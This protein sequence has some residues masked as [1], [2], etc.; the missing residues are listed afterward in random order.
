MIKERTLLTLST[1]CPRLNHRRRIAQDYDVGKRQALV[2]HHTRPHCA[3][4]RISEG[5]AN[6]PWTE[7]S[8]RVDQSA[9]LR[10]SGFLG[11]SSETRERLYRAYTSHVHSYSTT[12]DTASRD[13]SSEAVCNSGVGGDPYNRIDKK[14][15]EPPEREQSLVRHRGVREGASGS[16]CCTSHTSH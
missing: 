14:L 12:V 7:H 8:S 2:L 3:A 13:G 6:F 10:I 5:L 16:W 11:N 1:S 9:T 4:A 15:T